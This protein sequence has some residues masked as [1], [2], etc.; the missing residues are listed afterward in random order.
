MGKKYKIILSDPA[1][2]YKDKAQA[3]KRGV[4][5]KYPLL[6]INEIKKLPVGRIAAD[7]SIL[8]LWA[9]SPLLKEALETI[10]AWG[11]AYKTV[12]FVWVKKNKKTPTNFWGMGHYTRSNAEFVL[13][14][15]KGKTRDLIASHKIH[16]II[17]SPI[18]IHS[19]KPKIVRKK[20]ETLCKKGSKIEIFA[21]E[22][23]DNWDA[24][25]YRVD[26]KD[27]RQALIDISK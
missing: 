5:F 17:E 12:G 18:D 19:R 9:T 21:T 26:N 16:Q 15:T 1:W 6:S 20:I 24:I 8:F 2:T 13:I 25:G 7:T 14:G 10:D 23:T 22:K 11:F 4:N 27:I 3:G